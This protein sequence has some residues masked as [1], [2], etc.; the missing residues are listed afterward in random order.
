MIF[1]DKF[2]IGTMI[3]NFGVL[4]NLLNLE[5]IVNLFNMSF[6]ELVETQI[7][8]R[9]IHFKM[10]SNKDLN[11]DKHVNQKQNKNSGIINS[12]VKN[13]LN[14]KL[15]KFKNLNENAKKKKINKNTK[16]NNDGS[17]IKKEENQITQIY[18][19]PNVSFYQEPI[20]KKSFLNYLKMAEE[21]KDG[22]IMYKI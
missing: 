14:A 22:E 3:C 8:E 19:I 16:L 7:K 18:N 2:H 15:L 20:F 4:E 5:S 21:L 1:S 9:I 10:I 6:V 17:L 11:F 12:T 13:I